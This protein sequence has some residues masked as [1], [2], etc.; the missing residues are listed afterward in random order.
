MAIINNYDKNLVWLV[1]FLET[2]QCKRKK[3]KPNYN[4]GNQLYKNKKLVK[5]KKKKKPWTTELNDVD[6]TFVFFHS[7]QA[8]KIITGDSNGS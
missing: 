5:K 6:F 2:N 1:T 4:Y 7:F 8:H 3:H